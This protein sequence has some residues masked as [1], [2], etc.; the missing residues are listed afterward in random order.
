M[1]K[2]LA[3]KLLAPF[4]IEHP[5]DISIEHI[6]HYYQIEIHSFSSEC[7]LAFAIPLEDK[8]CIFISTHF[9]EKMRNVILAEEFSHLQLHTVNELTISPLWTLK[10]EKQARTLASYLLIPSFLLY[11]SLQYTNSINELATTF[12]VP[13]SFMTF[14]LSLEQKSKRTNRLD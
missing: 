6:C 7:S 4:S 9:S 2:S 8:Q 10:I 11:R 1:I 13:S 14:R 12:S 3:T 5:F